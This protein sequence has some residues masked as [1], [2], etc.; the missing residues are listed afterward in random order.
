M[1]RPAFL[2]V[3][4]SAMILSGLLWAAQGSGLLA[5]PAASPMIGSRGWIGW[6]LLLALGGLG[7]LAAARRG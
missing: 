3:L 7:V 2:R 1:A 6:G 5:W 4:G